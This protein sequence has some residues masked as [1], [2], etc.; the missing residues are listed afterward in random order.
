[1]FNLRSAYHWTEDPVQES[2]LPVEFPYGGASFIAAGPPI[3]PAEEATADIYPIGLVSFIDISLAMPRELNSP[4]IEVG[5]FHIHFVPGGIPLF[6]GQMGKILYA[7]DS[8]LKSLFSYYLEWDETLQRTTDN[9]D[10]NKFP[11][12]YMPDVN[13]IPPNSGGYFYNVYS[14]LF[15]YP[16]GMLIAYQNMVE[17]PR[18]SV[19]PGAPGMTIFQAYAER[20]YLASVG[21]IARIE[22]GQ[23][24]LNQSAMFYIGYLRAIHTEPLPPISD[25][26]L[27][28]P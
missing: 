26:N 10:P 21:P 14:S 7:R 11:E 24:V 18:S 17:A 8:L 20:S 22:Q 5:S 28:H 4:I 12:G 6:M 27:V 13:V 9:L 19:I 16:F 3:L 1:M 23:V 2:V 15:H 25:T